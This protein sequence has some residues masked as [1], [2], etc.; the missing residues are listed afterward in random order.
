MT[1]G[2]VTGRDLALCCSVMRFSRL[3]RMTS[4]RIMSQICSHQSKQA[5]FAYRMQ[6]HA[7][8]ACMC[9]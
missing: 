5:G 4:Q 2:S 1:G 6:L 3:K 8:D 9:L 7:D